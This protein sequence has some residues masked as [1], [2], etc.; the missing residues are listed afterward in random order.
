MKKDKFVGKQ[1]S[2]EKTDLEK[3]HTGEMDRLLVG[4][5]VQVRKMGKGVEVTGIVRG[6]TRTQSA[7][8]TTV[9][10]VG[11]TEDEYPR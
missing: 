2:V 8:T 6:N 7:S 10:Q 1:V 5:S 11:L 9:A 3:L 4:E